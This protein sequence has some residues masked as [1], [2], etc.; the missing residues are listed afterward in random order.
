[1]DCLV[2]TVF[3]HC[4]A[5]GLILYEYNSHTCQETVTH[6]QLHTNALRCDINC[7]YMA[8]AGHTGVVFRIM[9][10]ST[11]VLTRT[12]V[13][14]AHTMG[15]PYRYGQ[16][17]LLCAAVVCPGTLT[18]KL[19]TVAA[20]MPVC[21]PIGDATPLHSSVLLPAFWRSSI[22]MPSCTHG[23]AKSNFACCDASVL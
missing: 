20:C 22:L 5:C 4:Y 14:V 13:L 18:T 9:R 1:M 7:E 16:S 10:C 12:R 15:V 23:H 3:P 6:S 21:Y 19:T 11:A 17:S 8:L 2:T